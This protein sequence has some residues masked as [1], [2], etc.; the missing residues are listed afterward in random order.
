MYSYYV[1]RTA[2]PIGE[3]DFYSQMVLVFE[4]LFAIYIY[5]TIRNLLGSSVPLFPTL[6]II[7]IAISITQVRDIFARNEFTQ[8]FHEE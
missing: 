5:K 7:I 3:N 6:I 4:I 8:L 1:E 2:R